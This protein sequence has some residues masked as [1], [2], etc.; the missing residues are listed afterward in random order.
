MS[1][2][3]RTLIDECSIYEWI[4]Y[5]Q[6]GN[7]QWKVDSFDMNEHARL[8]LAF[9]AKAVSHMIA[10]L[11]DIVDCPLEAKP[12]YADAVRTAKNALQEYGL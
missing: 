6:T 5:W 8:E 3:Q 9:A 4:D 10:T 2:N 12:E 7:N 11:R 1:E